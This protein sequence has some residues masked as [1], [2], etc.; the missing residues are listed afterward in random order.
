[1]AAV[2]SATVLGRCFSLG[3]N[4][5][6][7]DLGGSADRSKEKSRDQMGPR[8]L[9]RCP[10][11]DTS[12]TIVDVII[13]ISNVWSVVLVSFCGCLRLK[14]GASTGQLVLRSWTKRDVFMIGNIRTYE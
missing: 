2:I 11:N 14:A 4:C 13:G 7:N 1:M 10:E 9:F 5:F 12:F 8:D 3:L 6:S